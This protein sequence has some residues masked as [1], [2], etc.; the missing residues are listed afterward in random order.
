MPYQLFTNLVVGI[1]A[2]IYEKPGTQSF[3]AFSRHW[4]FIGQPM[5]YLPPTSPDS[6]GFGAVSELLLR[7]E[8]CMFAGC[9][10]LSSLGE[11]QEAAN[12]KIGR[13]IPTNAQNRLSR[14]EYSLNDPLNYIDPS[15][16]LPVN[17]GCASQPDCGVDGWTGLP[18]SAGAHPS[19]GCD[20]TSER[21]GENSLLAPSATP[22]LSKPPS[23]LNNLPLS[24]CAA[25]PAASRGQLDLY[26]LVRSRRRYS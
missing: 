22:R 24:Q 20:S 15:G 25:S 10:A 13:E 8:E 5:S 17:T 26:S 7:I 9:I 1:V 3:Q 6:H 21:S 14:L 12:Y 4:K 2:N 18:E 23:H 11:L 19:N 16:H